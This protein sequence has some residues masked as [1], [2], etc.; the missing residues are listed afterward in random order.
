MS[1]ISLGTYRHYKGNEYKVIAIAKH[2]E[3]SEDMV[4]YQALYEPFDYWVRPLEMFNETVEVEGIV[5]PRFT[6]IEEGQSG[7]D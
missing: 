6:Y 2:T 1:E 4:V 7:T 3:T 5:I